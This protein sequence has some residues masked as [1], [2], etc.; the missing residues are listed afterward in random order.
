MLAL[1]LRAVLR[2]VP[3]DRNLD[4]HKVRWPHSRMLCR[5]VLGVGASRTESA[6]QLIAYV[7]VFAAIGHT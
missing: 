6:Q 2:F 1:A 5:A 3:L 4:W 7:T